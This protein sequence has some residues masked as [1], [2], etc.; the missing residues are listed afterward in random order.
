MET[1]GYT[2]TLNGI[3]DGTPFVAIIHCYDIPG[4]NFPVSIMI[5]HWK[6]NCYTP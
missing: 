4:E 6:N 5:T 1:K 2:T 3:S